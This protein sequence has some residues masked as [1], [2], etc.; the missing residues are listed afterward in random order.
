MPFLYFHMVY[1]LSIPSRINIHR[2]PTNPY[3]AH[4]LTNSDRVSAD[5]LSYLSLVFK[6]TWSVFLLVFF[7]LSFYTLMNVTFS[8][9]S[10]LAEMRHLYSQNLFKI[11]C[12]LWDQYYFG[13]AHHCVW[14][15][16][17]CLEQ[18]IISFSECVGF[19]LCS[20]R[21]E[22]CGFSKTPEEVYMFSVT[23]AIGTDWDLPNSRVQRKDT[24]AVT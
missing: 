12:N 16:T 13:R 22:S 11:W 6:F 20:S 18:P 15:R 8:L 4:M 10:L 5:F 19:K 17:L 9:L 7:F 24:K 21:S 1:S 23:V 3:S 14:L 2:N